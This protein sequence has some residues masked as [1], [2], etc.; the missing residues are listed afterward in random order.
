LLDGLQEMRV[1][2]IELQEETEPLGE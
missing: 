2:W 1:E